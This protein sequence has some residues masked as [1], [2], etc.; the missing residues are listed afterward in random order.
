M[1][2]DCARLI[3]NEV[4]QQIDSLRNAVVESFAIHMRVL[5]KFFFDKKPQDTDVVAADFFNDSI[6]WNTIRDQVADEVEIV[7]LCHRVNKEV[8]HLTYDRLNVK[9]EEKGWLKTG[10]RAYDII[11]RAYQKFIATV[12]EDVIGENLIQEKKRIQQINRGSG[13]E[14]N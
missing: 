14:F 6:T 5:V 4:V 13:L 7:K 12:P 9:P 1:F 11:A 8:A 2:H 10:G 3:E